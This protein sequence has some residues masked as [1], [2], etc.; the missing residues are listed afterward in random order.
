MT[1]SIHSLIRLAFTIALALFLA[2]ATAKPL[3]AAPPIWP[4]PDLAKIID[5]GLSKNKEIQSLE[6]QITSLKEEIPFAGSLADPRVGIGLLNLP[7]DTFR[8]DQEPMTQKQLFIA[9]KIPWFGKLSLKTQMA[10]LKAYRQEAILTAKKLELARQIAA[11]YFELGFIDSSRKINERLSGMV[12][13]ILRMTEIGYATGQGLH[14]DVILAQVE[15][16]KLLDEKIMLGKKYRTLEDKINELLNRESFT[17]VNPPGKMIYP[18]VKLSVKKLQAQALKNNPWIK[19]R[20]SDVKQADLRVELAMKDYWP[21][22]D[23]KVAYGQ[24][25]E[26][27]TGRDLDDFVSASVVI[28][29]PLWKETRQDKKLAASKADRQAAMNSYQNLI[30]SLPHKV[31]AISAEVSY[32]Q[33]SYRFMADAM[34]T[35]AEQLAQSSMAAYQVGKVEFATMI[36]ARIQL[37]RLELKAEKYLF[38]IYQKLAELEE[39]IGGSL[40]LQDVAPSPYCGDN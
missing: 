1:N 40:L 23:F 19:V 6:A 21:D 27:R 15:F 29:I 17:P 36:R 9:Q 25:D 3:R 16:S 35:Q 10:V 30:K 24:R 39:I 20:E 5:E 13:R 4:P 18:D 14:Q 33:N 7:V 2:G 8:F 38:D 22:M 11:A 34:I 37:L 32:T 12:N 26:D 28:N 31:D